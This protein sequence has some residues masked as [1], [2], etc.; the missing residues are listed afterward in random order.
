M[1][2]RAISKYDFYP[3]E[4]SEDFSIKDNLKML[5]MS[6]EN[7]VK[8]KRL[9]ELKAQYASEKYPQG[10][11]KILDEVAQ[12]LVGITGR[13]QE[14]FEEQK[15]WLTK[16]ETKINKLEWLGDEDADDDAYNKVLEEKLANKKEIDGMKAET[17]I[18]KDKADAKKEKAKALG[19]HQKSQVNI[20]A[21][22][23]K[24]AAVDPLRVELMKKVKDKP[25]I[26]NLVRPHLAEYE[27]TKSKNYEDLTPEQKKLVDEYTKNKKGILHPIHNLKERNRLVAAAGK[28]A[29]EIIDKTGNTDSSDEGRK[30][31]TETIKGDAQ[32]TDK[33]ETRKTTTETIKGNNNNSKSRKTE[34]EIIKPESGKVYGTTRSSTG[35]HSES[36]FYNYYDTNLHDFNE[37]SDK[38]IP[39]DMNKS[40]LLLAGSLSRGHGKLIAGLS[41]GALIAYFGKKKF[42]KLASEAR[43]EGMG[44]VEYIKFKYGSSILSNIPAAGPVDNGVPSNPLL[45]TY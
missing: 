14:Y 41:I 9:Q 33:P 3:G 34:V 17:Q 11:K 8:Y 32:K 13:G 29:S 30:T 31:T 26:G 45:A 1:S 2:Y 10:W 35:H 42:D 23:V 44:L 22:Q 15:K 36:D 6:K 24:S 38:D 28:E 12:L 5:G 37:G 19:E 39:E 43:E 21:G 7:R 16:M 27:T 20:A 25:I 40:R 18:A 4:F